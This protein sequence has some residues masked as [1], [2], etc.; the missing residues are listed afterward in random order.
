MNTDKNKDCR[1]CK[2]HAL[3]TYCTSYPCKT[4]LNFQFDYKIY[5]MYEPY[6]PFKSGDFIE[7]ERVLYWMLENPFK[8][9]KSNYHCH[10]RYNECIKRFESKPGLSGE[11]Q[12]LSTAYL[13]IF[14]EYKWFA[15]NYN[16]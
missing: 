15:E 11:W 14:N 13:K 6:E 10:I 2:W 8:E 12:A 7:I 3:S 16:K 9:L 4:C 5:N 1:T